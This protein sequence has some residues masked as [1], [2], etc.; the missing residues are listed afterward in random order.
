M[1]SLNIARLRSVFLFILLFPILTSPCNTRSTISTPLIEETEQDLPGIVPSTIPSTQTPLPSSTIEQ[2]CVS[3]EAERVSAYVIHVVDGDTID[4]RM[5]QDIFRVRYIGID[6]PESYQQGGESAKAANEALVMNRE[7]LLVKDVSDV[8]PYGR[9]LRYV[10]VGKT[11]VN[12]ELI[13]LGYAQ[14]GAWPPDIACY[15]YF[16]NVTLFAKD[17]GR[18]IWAATP[19][20]DFA[21]TSS[22]GCPN[23]CTIHLPGCDIKGNISLRS[24]EKIYHVPGQEDYEN[25]VISPD[26]GERWFCNEQEAIDNGWRKA[27][28]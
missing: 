8:D 13:R 16:L 22:T 14:A 18:G 10:F 25:T 20:P 7:V 1:S 9:L 23:G 17:E 12:Y 24:G 27:N 21:I 3:S 4:V 28:R 19:T 15:D 6:A 11:F 26:K 2:I 5:G